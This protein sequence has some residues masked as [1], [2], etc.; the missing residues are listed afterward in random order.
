MRRQPAGCCAASCQQAVQPSTRHRLFSIIE[1]KGGEAS[2]PCCC[3]FFSLHRAC[4]RIL[5]YER[6]MPLVCCCLGSSCIPPIVDQAALYG[7]ID[8][9]RLRFDVAR[10]RADRVALYY[11]LDC[12]QATTLIGCIAAHRA[13]AGH[14]GATQGGAHGSSIM[15]RSRRRPTV[16]VGSPRVARSDIAAIP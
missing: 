8:R 3:C 1:A 16:A 13:Y 10:R 2:F 6:A 9:A 7:L 4:C 15:N 5:A 11:R 14:V 12:L